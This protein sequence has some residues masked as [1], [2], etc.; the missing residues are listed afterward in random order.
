MDEPTNH[1]DVIDVA[2]AKA[3]ILVVG[4]RTH[5]LDLINVTWSNKYLGSLTDTMAIIVSVPV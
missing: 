5:H 3:S 1:L 4:E 2:D